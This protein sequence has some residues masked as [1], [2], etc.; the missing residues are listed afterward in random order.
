MTR[1]YGPPIP[2]FAKRILRSAHQGCCHTRKGND[3]ENATCTIQVDLIRHDKHRLS[4]QKLTA[5]RVVNVRGHTKHK[6]G[7]NPAPRQFSILNVPP[8]AS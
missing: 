6:V 2:L 4:H 8:S 7:G 3:K 5:K 1:V